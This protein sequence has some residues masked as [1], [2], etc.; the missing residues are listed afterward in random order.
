MILFSAKRR[1]RNIQYKKGQ[2]GSSGNYLYIFHALKLL[3]TISDCLNDDDLLGLKMPSHDDGS[4]DGVEL[5]ELEL[6]SGGETDVDGSR[7][8]RSKSKKSRLLY[9]MEEATSS[10]EEVDFGAVSEKLPSHSEDSES[11][12][13][14]IDSCELNNYRDT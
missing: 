2:H 9:S 7:G 6:S 10:E 11:E 3:L 4:T 5:S 1:S 13:E 12:F 8:H 14:I